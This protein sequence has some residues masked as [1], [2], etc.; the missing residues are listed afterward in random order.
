MNKKKLLSTAMAVCLG[1]VA[2]S[3]VAWD[4]SSQSDVTGLLYLRQ[5]FGVESRH[6]AEPVLGFNLTHHQAPLEDSQGTTSMTSRDLMGV[7]YG[8]EQSSLVKF[9]IGGMD[10][11]E[12]ELTVNAN[13]DVEPEPTGGVSAGA[14]IAGVVAVGLVGYATAGGG[15]NPDT[16]TGSAPPGSV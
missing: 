4:P 2:T 15:E 7:E 13:G 9:D 10:T 1:T 16:I 11:L 6:Q 3:V 5:P 14:I 8:V 12:Y